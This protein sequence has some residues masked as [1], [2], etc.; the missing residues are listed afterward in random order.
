MYAIL[1]ANVVHEV[2]GFNQPPAGEKFY[3][4]I[5]T[6]SGHLVIGGKLRKELYEGSP[7]FKKWAEEAQKAGRLRREDDGKVNTRTEELCRGKACKSDDPH[8]IALAQIGRVRLLYSNDRD[9]QKD[10]RN[11]A[12]IDNPRGRVYS[13]LK[14]KEFTRDHRRLLQKASR[15]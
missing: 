9:L 13:T 8:I 2:F 11:R 5:D 6:G 12:L 7:R 15:R 10:F 1:D 4:W 3:N 14:H